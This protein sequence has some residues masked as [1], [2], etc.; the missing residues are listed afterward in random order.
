MNKELFN[1]SACAIQKKEKVNLF[2]N[3]IFIKSFIF[4]PSLFKKNAIFLRFSKK[5][6]AIL[7]YFATFMHL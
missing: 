3:E 4:F 7:K 5:T 2:C 6:L 1:I